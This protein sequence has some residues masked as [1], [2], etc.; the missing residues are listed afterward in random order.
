MKRLFDE[1]NEKDDLIFLYRI[2]CQSF[3]QLYLTYV[4]KKKKDLIWRKE[5]FSSKVS[6]D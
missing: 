5:N 6:I 1:M 4:Y 2:A 3:K